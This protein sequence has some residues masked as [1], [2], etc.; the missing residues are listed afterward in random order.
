MLIKLNRLKTQ[1]FILLL[2]VS[3]YVVGCAGHNTVV[4]KPANELID[5]GILQFNKGNYKRAIE[6]FEQLKDWYPFSKFAILAELKIADAHFELEQYP[7]AVFAYEEFEKL[8]PRN[9]AV[10]YVIYQV[11]MS[12]YLQVDT[13]DRDQT[14]AH[15][16]VVAFRRLMRQYPTDSYAHLAQGYV[17][18]CIRSLAGHEFYVGIYYYR[19]KKYRAA[20]ERFK[21]LIVNYSDEGVHTKA[22]SY[23]KNCET[24][25]KI[26]EETESKED[27]IYFMPE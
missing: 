8:H 12:H 15:K 19:I 18:N 26:Q 25:L 2:V 10:P 1:I 3:F 11:G 5:D 24:L 14:S 21:K 7:D 20:L 13:V 16:A 27:E 6:S 4:E 17:D 23:I 22:L 9:E